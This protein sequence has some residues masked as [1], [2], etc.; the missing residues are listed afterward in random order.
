MTPIAALICVLATAFERRSG[1][2]TLQ[3]SACNS[4]K[5]SLNVHLRCFYSSSSAAGLNLVNPRL[6]QFWGDYNI[7]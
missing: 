7:W 1:H 2:Q 6:P 4:D 3:R 5:G